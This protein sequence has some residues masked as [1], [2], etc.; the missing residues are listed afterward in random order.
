M[1]EHSHNR[2]DLRKP[3]CAVI[4]VYRPESLKLSLV[5]K[6]NGVKFTNSVP[7]IPKCAA[8]NELMMIRS[9]IFR[10]FFWMSN[11]SQNSRLL[12]EGTYVL[13]SPFMRLQLR[14][15]FL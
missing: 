1:I 14:N 12:V 5:V 11:I 15:F 3:Y 10:D 6:K 13:G 9:F 2:D 7:F 4:R 8:V